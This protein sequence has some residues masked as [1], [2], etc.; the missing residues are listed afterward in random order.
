M[1]SRQRRRRYGGRGGGRGS[2]IRSTRTTVKEIWFKDGSV[3]GRMPQIEQR[4]EAH[5]DGVIPGDHRLGVLG[6]PASRPIPGMKVTDSRSRARPWSCG[7]QA[8][9]SGFPCWATCQ[10]ARAHGRSHRG[11]T[12]KC[13]YVHDELKFD[14]SST[15]APATCRR[16]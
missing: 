1:R 8:D 6:C 7:G 4:I 12:Q 5:R 3:G 9:R 11:W 15:T 13:A 2:R 10:L 16:H 14:P